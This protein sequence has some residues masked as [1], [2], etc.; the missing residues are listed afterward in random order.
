MSKPEALYGE[1]QGVVGYWYPEMDMDMWINP[2]KKKAENWEKYEGLGFLPVELFARLI[3]FFD[4]LRGYSYP[5]SKMRD[6]AEA[7]Y[8]EVI[9]IENPLKMY[10]KLKAVKSWVEYELIEYDKR[11]LH[12]AAYKLERDR[13]DRLIQLDKILEAS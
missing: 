11:R 2:I 4:E 13:H 6:K 1:L 12:F 10:E 7:L 8:Q 5:N 3:R 9:L